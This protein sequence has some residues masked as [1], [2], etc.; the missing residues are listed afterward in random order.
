MAA[1]TRAAE[2]APTEPVRVAGHL[3]DHMAAF[4]TTPAT[5]TRLRPDNGP[6]K[7]KWSARRAERGST[8]GPGT[9]PEFDPDLAQR[10]RRWFCVRYG[11]AEHN[12][13]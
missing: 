7:G 13:R 4:G 2:S 8:H 12:D 5:L 10:R 6:A 9:V 1:S 3:P 11:A